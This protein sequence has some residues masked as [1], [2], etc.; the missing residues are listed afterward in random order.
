[1]PAFPRIQ[2]D[3]FLPVVY[4][5][6]RH[7]ASRALDSE[8]DSHTFQTTELVHET[9]IR[10]SEIEEIEWTNKDHVLRASVCVMRRVLIDHARKKKSQKRNPQQLV[11]RCPNQGFNEAID[12]P[13]EL[14]LLALDEALTRLA[15]FDQRKAEVV[16][17][18]YFGG[19]EIATIARLLNLSNATVKRDWTIAR[20]WLLRELS[21]EGC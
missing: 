15:E 6:L 8:R 17:L 1:M 9:Y 21:G 14:D 18:R 16:E 10:L 13:P 4:D 12:P 11:L 20:A 2:L 19:Q 3:E 7:C 5:Q